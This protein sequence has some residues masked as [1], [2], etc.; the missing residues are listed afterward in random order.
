M[1][2]NLNVVVSEHGFV[3]QVSEIIGN[4]D[5]LQYHFYSEVDSHLNRFPEQ[6]KVAGD[7]CYQWVTGNL[8]G[9]QFPSLIIQYIYDKAKSTIILVR[10]EKF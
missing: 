5:L 8:L 6:D 1:R 7:G 2:I 10:I 9:D 4:D 3:T